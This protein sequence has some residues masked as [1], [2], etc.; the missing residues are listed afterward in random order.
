MS[1]AP[2]SSISSLVLNLVQ[3]QFGYDIDTPDYTANAGIRNTK[4]V[5][6]KPALNGNE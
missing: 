2:H 6:K 5:F 4:H 3:V 1:S